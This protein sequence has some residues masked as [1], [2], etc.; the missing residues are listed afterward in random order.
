L[1]SISDYRRFMVLCALAFAAVG[2]LGVAAGRGDSHYAP[3]AGV[4]SARTTDASAAGAVFTPLQ[5]LLS[6]HLTD[7][8]PEL[9]FARASQHSLL[10]NTQIVSYYGNPATADM[11]V[12]GTADLETVLSQLEERAAWYDALNGPINVVPAVHL[13]YAVAQGHPTDNG[14]YLQYTDDAVVRRLLE[15][16]QERGMLLFLDL[17]MGRSSVE[18]ELRNVLPYLRYPNVHLALDPEFAVD[19]P[20]VPGSDIGSLHATDVDEAQAVLQHLVSSERLPPKLLIVHQF[21]DSMISDG[22][23]IRRYPG[24]ELVID[25]DGFGPAAVK[26]ATYEQYAARPYA[27]HAAIKLFLQHDPDLMTAADVLALRPTPAIVIY[28]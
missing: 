18:D 28:Q 9:A 27:T 21:L 13:V 14:L 7:R 12:L 8:F 4:A 22:D 2:A 23:A 5:P 11:G 3:V 26:R 17:Q 16:T 1:H 19:S 24:V 10:P 20:E 25:M 6:V 15:L